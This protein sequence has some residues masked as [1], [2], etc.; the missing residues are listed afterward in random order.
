MSE[1]AVLDISFEGGLDLV[2]NSV[3]LFN[4][5]GAAVELQN[6]ESSAYGGY[7]RIN[8]YTKFGTTQPAGSA[9]KIF[10]VAPY[11]DG[12]ISCQGTS[13]YFSIDGTT[14]YKIN[15]DISGGGDLTALQAAAELPRTNQSKCDFAIYHNETDYGEVLI[16]DGV[17]EV[18]YFKIT[19]TGAGRTY[20]YKELGTSTGAPQAPQFGLIYKDRYVCCG[21][22]N[23]PNTIYWSTRYTTDDFTGASA[24]ALEIDSPITGA[25]SFREKLF[26][27]TANSIFLLADIDSTVY[28]QS[29][30]RNIG[31]IDGFSIQEIGGDLV[32]LSADGLRTLNGTTRIGDVGLAVISSKITPL[33]QD[34][35]NHV[36]TGGEVSSVVLRSKNQYRLFYPVTGTAGNEQKGII[37]TLKID[38]TGVL[39]WEWSSVLGVEVTAISEESD[40]IDSNQLYHGDNAGY[41][42]KHDFGNSFNTAN[43]IAR[44]RTPYIH[45]GNMAVR[46]TLYAT[47]LTLRSEG[48]TT[49]KLDVSYDFGSNQVHQ[50]S[51]Y[52]LPTI[53]AGA[54][55]GGM[56]LGTD[57][58]GA[59][60]LPAERYLLEGGGFSNNYLFSTSDTEAP[61]TLNGI[62]T[63]FVSTNKLR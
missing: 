1:Q 42:Y 12:I 26:I 6:F 15:K 58:L 63:E 32:F 55:L 40:L 3:Q 37:G 30:T 17:N 31:C 60:E 36:L 21:D 24:G 19:G 34:I 10:G 46:K 29:V 16:T 22:A 45:Y 39:T 33:I 14:W 23:T 25:I 49:L 62:T 20:Y 53:E 2:S 4:T 27:F 9:S 28:S 8:G 18:G 43:V 56:I 50:P 52:T 7:R 13:I 54:L 57:L 47:T 48:S 61:Y 51:Q 59:I 5:P 44:F 11:A 41:T 38:Q 35:I